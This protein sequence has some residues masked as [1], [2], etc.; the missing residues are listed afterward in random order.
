MIF[1]QNI[2]FLVILTNFLQPA[3]YIC[4][5]FFAK[6]D[7]NLSVLFASSSSISMPERDAA[8]QSAKTASV[9]ASAKFSPPEA[10]VRRSAAGSAESAASAA[11]SARR[12]GSPKGSAAADTHLEACSAA[13]SALSKPQPYFFA[14]FCTFC[15][16]MRAGSC[17][18]IRVS[19]S[20]G[21]FS[22][23]SFF[24]MVS[25]LSST[26]ALPETNVPPKTWGGG[27]SFSRKCRL[28]RRLYRKF[29]FLFRSRRET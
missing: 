15:A 3:F 9:I 28:S 19:S 18:G 29:P 11:G 26:S 22:D 24:L 1:L 14:F 25:Q 17:L 16:R 20:S 8:A 21:L 2:D 4:F 27:R 10:A 13:F 7:M 12:E 5:S 6:S 23:F